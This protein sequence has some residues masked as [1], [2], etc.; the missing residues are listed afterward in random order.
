MAKYFLAVALRI[1]NLKVTIILHLATLLNASSR[2]SFYK[3]GVYYYLT[4]NS[5][6]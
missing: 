4:A 2:K 3:G 6:T 5:S 1:Q